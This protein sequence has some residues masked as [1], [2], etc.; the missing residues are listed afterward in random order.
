MVLP[1]PPGML[2]SWAGWMLGAIGVDEL[3]DAM[4]DIVE[5]GAS[6]D[7]FENADLVK[8]ARGLRA[9]QIRSSIGSMSDD[10]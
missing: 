1:N 3:A 8:Y 2:N 7:T 10:A 5:T 4:I 6:T 9:D